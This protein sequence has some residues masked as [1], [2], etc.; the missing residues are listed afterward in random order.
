[1]TS[2]ILL[3]TVFL[4]ALLL[5]VP[6][7]FWCQGYPKFSFGWFFYTHLSIPI[8]LLIIANVGIGLESILPSLT[9]FII[10]QSLGRRI[11]IHWRKPPWDMTS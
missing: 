7:G 11:A 4:I 8:I 5:N 9:G 10:G 2:Y 3:G 1:M 6:L